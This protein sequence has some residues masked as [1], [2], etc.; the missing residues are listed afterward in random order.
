M[1]VPLSH[2]TP[3]YSKTDFMLVPLSHTTPPYSKT[4]FMN[5]NIQ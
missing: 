2:T 1:L 4:D 3:P 5:E